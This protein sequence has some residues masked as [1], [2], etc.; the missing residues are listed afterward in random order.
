MLPLFIS[1]FQ[2]RISNGTRYNYGI[3][4]VLNCGVFGRPFVKWSPYAIGLLSV[5]SVCDVG[6]LWPNDWM[7]QDTTW[8]GGRP[9]PWPYCVRWGPSTLP[10]RGTAPLP[11]FWPMSLWQNG[12]MDQDATW[13]EGRPR[14]RPH[15]VRWTPS[16]PQKG[17]GP[18]FRPLS[19]V[20]KRLYGLRCHLVRS[21][22]S[23]Q[24]TLCLDGDP[25]PPKQGHSTP[26]FRPMY[27]MAKR[28]PISASAELVCFS[29]FITLF[30]FGFVWQTKLAIRQLL[31]AR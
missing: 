7:D 1:K 19:V 23:A 21:Y 8:H 2:S 30:L 16:S 20:A 17:T 5:L 29:F 3:Q 26:T 24:A 4:Q 11:N 27:I 12:W 10:K 6:V 31:G 9:R 22:A 15:C 25:T 14:P 13:Y 28:S 18:N